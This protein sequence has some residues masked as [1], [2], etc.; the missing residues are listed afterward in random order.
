[1]VE[2][3]PALH[4][5]VFQIYTH[6]TRSHPH[7]FAIFDGSTSEAVGQHHIHFLVHCK[8]CEHQC[9]YSVVTLNDASEFV[10]F[11]EYICTV[12]LDLLPATSELPSVQFQRRPQT[13]QCCD[14]DESEE[15]NKWLIQGSFPCLY[16]LLL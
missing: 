2:P 12:L 3:S 8:D 6:H 7:Q 13:H 9:I 1:M 16:R 14:E 11:S 4:P 10:G 5:I 15:D